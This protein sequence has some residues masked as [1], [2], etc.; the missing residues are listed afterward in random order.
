MT[1][2][3]SNLRTLGHHLRHLLHVL[4]HNP[5]FTSESGGCA[6]VGSSRLES[7]E[8]KTD[9]APTDAPAASLSRPKHKG[10]LG[11]LLG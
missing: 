7:S 8:T 9:E 6:E 11:I 2:I 5:Q 4:A 10:G 3:C 1:A